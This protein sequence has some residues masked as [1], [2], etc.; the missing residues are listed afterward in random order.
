MVAV[1]ADAVQEWAIGEIWTKAPT[2]WPVCRHHPST[3][4][5]RAET[6]NDVAVWACPV[7]GLLSGQSRTCDVGKL[8]CSALTSR[9]AGRMCSLRSLSN[10]PVHPTR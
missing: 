10:T 8:C 9:N 6:V 7:N 2:N 3:R 5:L 4:P 1:V